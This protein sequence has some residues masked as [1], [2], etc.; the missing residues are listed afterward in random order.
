VPKVTVVIPVYNVEAYLEVCLLSLSAQKYK[1]L[2]VILVNDG[3]TDESLRVATSFQK[4]LNLEIVNQANSGL[5]SARN[6]G[7]NA[8][9]DTDYL[10]FLDSD[11]AL[12]SKAIVKMVKLIEETGSDFVLGDTTRMKGVTRL[13]RRDTRPVFAKGTLRATN[14]K[15]HPQSILDV[16]AWNRLFKYSF[17]SKNNLIFPHGLYFEDMAL[18]TQALISAERFDVLAKSIYLWRVRTE[19]VKSITQQ[20]NDSRKLNDRIIALEEMFKI[21]NMA[22]QAGRAD[23]HNLD[24]LRSRIENHDK[25]LYKEVPGATERFEELLRKYN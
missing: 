15:D 1:N 14:I 25:T 21:V 4:V 13:K 22:M 3:S 16:T 17:Y 2:S 5:S 6:S 7:V 23:V 18:M 19:G 24:A 11:D 20:P 9:R 12:Q 10:M 8:I